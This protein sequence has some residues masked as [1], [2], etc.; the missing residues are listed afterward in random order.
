LKWKRKIGSQTERKAGSETKRKEAKEAKGSEITHVSFRFEA[1][2]KNGK[3]NEA[4]RSKKS[5]VCFAK[6]REM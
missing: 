6:T 3:R 4:K 1:K 2:T 5:F